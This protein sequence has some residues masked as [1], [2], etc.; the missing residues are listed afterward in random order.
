MIIHYDDIILELR[1][2]LQGTL[3]GISNR[4]GT[5]KDGDNDR[6]LQFKGLFL[7]IHINQS[8]CIHQCTDCL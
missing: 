1:F 5:I 8:R 2:L 6:S 7:E 3:H 4:L